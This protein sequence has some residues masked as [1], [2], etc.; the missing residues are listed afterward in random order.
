[1]NPLVI[2]LLVLVVG[3]A[4]RRAR[5]IDIS[6]LER[7]L[8]SR[9]APVVVAG[10]SAAAVWAAW[11]SLRAV[12]VVQDESAYVLQARIF[13]MG[14]WAGPPRPIPAFFEQMAVFGAPALVP[15]YPP[16]H[17]LL[18][19][20]GIWLGLPGLI[21]V[22]LTAAAGALLFALARRVAG[23]WV[24]AVALVIWLAS[25]GNIQWRASYLSQTTTS[26]A[27]LL[28]WWCLLRWRETHG[29][30][31]S[32]GV[33]ASVAW[34]AITRP[35]TAVALATP[36]AVVM[37]RDLVRQRKWGGALVPAAVGGAILAIVPLWSART[38]GDWRATPYTVYM[39]TY[40][41]TE[42]L[43]FG[44]VGDVAPRPLP[45]DL[46]RVDADWRRVHAMHTAERLPTTLLWR[47]VTVARGT[48]SGWRLALLPFF[49]IGL[50]VLGAEAAL[51]LA[52]VALLF[53]IHV[54]FAHP[55]LWWPYYLEALPVLAV[56]TALGL[57]RVLARVADDVRASRRSGGR[58]TRR[59]ALAAAVLALAWIALSAGD[60]TR[61][62]AAT[63]AT[64]AAQETF[65]RRVAELPD[66]RAIVFVRYS[67]TH[68][69]HRSLI[70][71]GPDLARERV[72]IAYD[73]GAEN[74]TL[75]ALAPDRACYLYDEARDTFVR[76][77][78]DAR[79]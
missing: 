40:I 26:A 62:R 50:T 41:P 48:W 63:I 1:V 53:G 6:A 4:A 17:A 32:A 74:V 39:K 38:L 59:A 60:V 70:T 45:P 16:G 21:P 24:A 47:V 37:L 31:W 54:A 8:A 44:L 75:H 65:A 30:A 15:K 34:C 42:R 23:V 29:T 3:L 71:N 28:A 61:A 51:A 2:L 33:A 11:G 5:A 76:L 67:P 43:G 72:W 56:V 12:P 66:P 77:M 10:V 18:L 73:R 27:W 20:P 58:D 22:L 68:D 64:R 57:W 14:Q 69:Q 7:A 36:I 55:A 49:L 19:V 35:V 9:W 52:S 79:S 78:M 46:A 13:A 25:S